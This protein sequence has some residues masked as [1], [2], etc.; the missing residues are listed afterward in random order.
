[1]AVIDR[2]VSLGPFDAARALPLSDEARWNQTEADWAMMLR[3]GLGFGV[4]VD[5]RLVASAVALPYGIVG[6]ISMV[7]VTASARRQGLATQ[8]VELSADALTRNGAR[9]MLDATPAGQAV[10]RKMGFT[11]LRGLTRWQGEGGPR[12][13]PAAGIRRAHANDIDWIAALDRRAFGLDRRG[14]LVNILAR[15][16]AP[17]F[18]TER[19]DGF[20]LGRRGRNAVQLGPIT[21]AS[22]DD[23]DALF[24]T[25]LADTAGPVLVDAFDDR[26]SITRTLKAAG[27]APQRTFARMARGT[28]PLVGEEAL[29]FAAAGPELG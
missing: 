27:F 10:Y 16:G 1:M 8:L 22:A 3:L 24:N 14:I 11:P 26:T 7:L 20:L 21:A 15:P 13:A 19:R 29:T 28:E 17:V 23:A 9:P 25:A 12:E 5:D 4:E 2:P 6:W 18:V